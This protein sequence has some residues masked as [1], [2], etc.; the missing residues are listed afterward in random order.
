MYIRMI[1]IIRTVAISNCSHQSIS[2]EKESPLRAHLQQSHVEEELEDGEEWYVE[3]QLDVPL[4]RQLRH[5]LLPADQAGHEERVG[6]DGDH[7]REAQ[8][9]VDSV[10]TNH[11]S[12]H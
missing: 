5:L 3:V 1:Y 12:V 11:A 7:L 10:W 4:V 2:A 6:R 8:G 9:A